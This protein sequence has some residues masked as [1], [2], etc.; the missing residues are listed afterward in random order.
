MTTQGNWHKD[1]FQLYWLD[2]NQHIMVIKYHKSYD[3]HGYYAMMEIAADMIEGL[4]HPVVYINE[5]FED[6]RIPTD[7]P[8]PHFSNMRRIFNPQAMILIPRTSQQ[9]QI[10]QTYAVSSNAVEG[11]NYWL[12]TT[13]DEAL[14][15]AKEQSERL[16]NQHVMAGDTIDG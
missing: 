12:A 6:V 13:F 7:S 16:R 15:I 3:W 1:I 2:D 14:I 5:W 9:M 11:E 4:T 10:I 8:I